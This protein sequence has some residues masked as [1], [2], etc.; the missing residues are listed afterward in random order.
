MVIKARRCGLISI[1]TAA[2]AAAVEVLWWRCCCEACSSLRN[3]SLRSFQLLP[4]AWFFTSPS[5]QQQQQQQQQTPA[6]TLHINI[7][8]QSK[9]TWTLMIPGEIP[10]LLPLLCNS[11]PTTTLT[12]PHILNKWSHLP[13]I[14]QWRLRGW[15]EWF[16]CVCVCKTYLLQLIETH[17]PAHFK[18]AL[19]PLRKKK[20]PWSS[21]EVGDYQVALR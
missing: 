7:R 6:I 13:W 9:H 2:S 15:V 18:L 10:V 14:R 21:A 5:Q 17:S 19:F 8:D 1:L 3:S 20:K 11:A 12:P 4:S 16:V